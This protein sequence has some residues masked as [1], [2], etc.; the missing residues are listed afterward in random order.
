MQCIPEIKNAAYLAFCFMT[1]SN[2]MT[3]FHVSIRKVSTLWQ[4][5]VI[6]LNISHLSLFAI[7]TSCGITNIRFMFCVNGYSKQTSDNS[8]GAMLHGTLRKDLH[9]NLFY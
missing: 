2:E 8:K 6:T 4:F 5:S 3:K 9:D 7:F 1:V